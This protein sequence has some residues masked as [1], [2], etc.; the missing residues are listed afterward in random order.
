MNKVVLKCDNVSKSY[1]DGQL[2]VNVLNQLRLE[3]LEGQSVS[4]I[5]SSGSG[6]STLMHILGGLDKPTSGSV[7]LMGQDLSQV[8]QTKMGVVGVRPLG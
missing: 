5:G 8:G 4:I 3:V 1:K 7:V 6:K 2:N